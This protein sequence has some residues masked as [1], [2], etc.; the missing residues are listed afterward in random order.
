MDTSGCIVVTDMRNGIGNILCEILVGLLFVRRLSMVTKK[1]YKYY[2]LLT[3]QVLKG[4]KIAYTEEHTTNNLPD[5]LSLSAVLP[6]INFI[7]EMPPNMTNYHLLQRINIAS[8]SHVER[9]CVRVDSIDNLVAEIQDHKDL[10]SQIAYAT[11][12]RTYTMKKYKIVK[13]FGGSG[14]GGKTLGIHLRL[15]QIGDYVK[16][17]FPTLA[18]YKKAVQ[19]IVRRQNGVSPSRIFLVSGLSSSESDTQTIF[20]EVVNMLKTEFPDASKTEIVIVDHEPYYVDLFL[21]SI[22]DNM[23]MS[24]STFSLVPGLCTKGWLIHPNVVNFDFNVTNMKNKIC[25][26]IDDKPLYHNW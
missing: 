8:L 19:E 24:N 22:C 20:N 23:I 16:T 10:L 26:N 9:L 1:D 11:A 21:L 2:A 5:P 13:F 18:W 17:A 3:G 15:H 6:N 14:G 7:T 12:I 4:H 25:L